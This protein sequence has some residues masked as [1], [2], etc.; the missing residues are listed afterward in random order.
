M[1]PKG[2]P[3]VVPHLVA[4][5]RH[6]EAIAYIHYAAVSGSRTPLLRS[7]KKAKLSARIMQ[8]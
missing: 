6:R 1:R 4:D 7:R 8:A 2:L 5:Q 3:V